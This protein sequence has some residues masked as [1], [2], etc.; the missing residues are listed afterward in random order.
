MD[1]EKTFPIAHLTLEQ[2]EK[3]KIL[4]EELRQQTEDNIVL[5]AYDEM[6]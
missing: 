3:I 2:L 4:E 6:G 1:K 5:I